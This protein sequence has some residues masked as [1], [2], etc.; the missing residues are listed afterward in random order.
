MQDEIVDDVV[1]EIEVEDAVAEDKSGAE[2]EAKVEGAPEDGTEDDGIDDELTVSIG[3]EPAPEPEDDRGAAPWV[4]DLRKTNRELVR[5]QR[6]QEALIAQLRGQG[7]QADKPA[8]IGEK[9]TLEGCEYDPDRFESELLSWKERRDTVEAEKRKQEDATKKA[10]DE[11]NGKLAAYER[12]K[13]A[14]KVRD[15]EDAEEVVLSTLSIT[16]QGVILS[17]AEKPEL[18]VYALG[19]NKAKAAEL[20][21]ITDPVKFAVAIGKLESQLKVQPRKSAPPP[22]RVI[23]G[24]GKGLVMNAAAL[25]K[26]REHAHQTGDMTAYYAAKRKMNSKG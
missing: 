21:A 5:K 14:L 22:E 11:W 3:D 8:T 12:S 15:F 1:D 4:R 2:D 26:L 25:E 6:E 9:P 19:K 24:A 23:S 10:Q 17:G 16:Q 13:Q 18:L 20:A 7:Q